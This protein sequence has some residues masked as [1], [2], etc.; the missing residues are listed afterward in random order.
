LV[1]YLTQKLDVVRS[2][3]I[4]LRASKTEGSEPT[5]RRVQWQPAKRSISQVE[6]PQS[7]CHYGAALIS[8]TVCYPERLLMLIDAPK[9]CLFDWEVCIGLRLGGGEAPV[10]F[11]PVFVVDDDVDKI[12]G[13][14]ASKVGCKVAHPIFRSG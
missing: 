2:E 12:E 1:R 11:I 9:Q 5:I 6:V 8:F 14:Q 4:G 7:L 3:R 13:K 10:R